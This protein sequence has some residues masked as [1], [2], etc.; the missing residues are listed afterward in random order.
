MSCGV[1]LANIIRPGPHSAAAS[2]HLHSGASICQR[3][4]HPNNG[5]E[6]LSE[7]VRLTYI[8]ALTGRAQCAALAVV[9]ACLNPMV[10]PHGRHAAAYSSPL[11]SQNIF[12]RLKNQNID[13][14]V[15]GAQPLTQAG[16][17]PAQRGSRRATAC[18]A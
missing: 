12:N 15:T 18:T 17:T 6:A 4:R 13:E 1:G 14:H 2:T 7:T 5:T 11:T 9:P 16:P 8:A 10:F 3:D